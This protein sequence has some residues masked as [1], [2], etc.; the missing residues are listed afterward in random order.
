MKHLQSR[1][2][3]FTL[4]EAMVTLA[5]SG[6]SVA[7]GLPALNSAAASMRLSATTNGYF[8]NLMLTRSE[9]ILRNSRAVLCKSADGK[10][11]TTSGG[12]EQGWLVFHDANNNA[13]VDA[14][15]ALL[16]SQSAL[17]NG[18]RL[19][20][21]QPLASYVSYTSD[22]STNYTSG[23]F[24]AGTFTLCHPSAGKTD[25]R[26]IVIASSGRPRVQR[27]TVSSCA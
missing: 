7:A 18:I 23:A 26:Q 17:P 24:Q 1:M 3:G 20:G 27:V 15:E 11:C 14:G 8:S 19:T 16:Q 6:I 22:G 21:N 13:K 10:T 25:A 9:A 4:V 2:A 12:W 5:L